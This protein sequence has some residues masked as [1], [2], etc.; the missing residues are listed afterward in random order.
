MKII[1]IGAGILG[2]STAYQLARR[3]AEVLM[4]DRRDAGQATD[5]A[6]GIICPWLTQRRNQAWYRLVKGGA[7][8]YP[9][10]IDELKQCGETDTGYA[11]VGA[12]H[13]HQDRD[14]IT[15]MS[16]RARIRK[17]D[18][19]EIGDISILGA[20]EVRQQFPLLTDAYEAVH[21]SGAARVDGRALR[22]SLIRAAQRHGAE[23][24]HGDAV[25]LTHGSRVIGVTANGREYDAQ[26]AIVCAGAWAGQ[27]LQPLGVQ[28]RVSCQKAQIMHVRT[29]NQTD[30][31]QW[32]VVMPPSN[33][34]MLAFE[35]GRLVLGS[36]HEDVAEA[37]DTE[38]TAGGMH[39]ILSK[40]LAVAP[41]LAQCSY[42]ETRVGFRPFTPGFLPVIGAIPGWEGLLTANGLGASGLTAGPYLGL[43]L[44]K[45]ALGQPLDLDLSDYDIQTALE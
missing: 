6:A 25:L 9:E 16:E 30:T 1:V 43:Q 41:G 38:P 42:E 27:L 15:G 37:Y 17:E 8:Y 14:R 2:A 19:P 44:A 12:L 10:L 32:P 22:D 11:R 39:E 3:G 35:Q 40:S 31:G 24:V 4:I 13:L 45:L 36:T 21:I 28:L 23:Y 20:E 33:H 34:Y 26:Q 5:A 29:T 7:R 18:A